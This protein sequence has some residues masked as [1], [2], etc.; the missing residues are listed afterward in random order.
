M[1][2]HLY[3]NPALYILCFSDLCICALHM[4]LFTI[5][6]V[7]LSTLVNFTVVLL[8]AVYHLRHPTLRVRNI[9]LL[10][11][12]MF[13]GSLWALGSLVTFN[14]AESLTLIHQAACGLTFFSMWVWGLNLFLTCLAVR[15][16]H[17]YT[18]FFG[19]QVQLIRVNQLYSRKCLIAAMMGLPTMVGL[20]LLGSETFEDPGLVFPDTE[21]AG[22]KYHTAIKVLMLSAVWLN[23]SVLLVWLYRVRP[24]SFKRVPSALNDFVPTLVAASLAWPAGVAISVL[25]MSNAWQTEVGRCTITI[26]TAGIVNMVLWILGARPLRTAL[27]NEEEAMESLQVDIGAWDFNTII[28]TKSMRMFMYDYIHTEGTSWLKAAVTMH[29]S[30]LRFHKLSDTGCTHRLHVAAARDIVK[31]FLQPNSK[32]RVPGMPNDVVQTLL[33][34]K[35]EGNELHMKEFSALRDSLETEMENQLHKTS[36]MYP[37]T[38]G[39]YYNSIK[40]KAQAITALGTCD[41]VLY[42]SLL[43]PAFQ[44]RPGYLL[45]LTRKR[46]SDPAVKHTP[47]AMPSEL[48]LCA[49]STR[50]KMDPPRYNKPTLCL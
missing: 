22:C 34:A 35:F 17:I 25:I 8:F 42:T 10:Y 47:P 21:R 11:T 37:T 40:R 27:R 4:D 36:F 15:L 38:A 9:H 6:F 32:H 30:L 13:S 43:H 26:L 24:R 41:Y 2:L 31:R 3:L 44:R 12:Q 45:R 18:V 19:S 7:L 20:V 5:I 14:H 1:A 50:N 23:M 33:N 49:P 28:H 39:N 16:Q 46:S 48:L 29:A